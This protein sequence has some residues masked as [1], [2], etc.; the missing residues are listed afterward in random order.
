MDDDGGRRRIL[1]GGWR[2]SEVL[3]T[4]QVDYF[5]WLDYQAMQYDRP[6]S[7]DY[8]ERVG[9]FDWFPAS[10]FHTLKREDLS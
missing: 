2:T 10:D 5:G 4:C 8:G 1:P 3:G 9:S 7:R 6:V